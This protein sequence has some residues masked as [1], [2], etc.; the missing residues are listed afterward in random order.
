MDKSFDL[1]IK[2]ARVVR[3]NKTSVDKL[4]M[5]VKDG[6]IVQ[7]APAIDVESARESFDAKNFW[8]SPAVLMLTCMSASIS[9][10]PRTLFR[11]VKRRRWAG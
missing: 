8:R 5:A 4:D 1:V 11:K 7:L 9:P 10:W 6:K 2:N 3:P